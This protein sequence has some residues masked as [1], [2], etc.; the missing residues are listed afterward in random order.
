[1]KFSMLLLSVFVYILFVIRYNCYMLFV[2]RL[3][4]S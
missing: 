2:V 4:L 3:R 1:M